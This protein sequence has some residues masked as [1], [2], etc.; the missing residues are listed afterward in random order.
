[1]QAVAGAS[2]AGGSAEF[3]LVRKYLPFAAVALISCLCASP[4]WAHGSSIAGIWQLNEG[5]SPSRL[6]I[7]QKTGAYACKEITGTINIDQIYGW[8][9]PQSRELFFTRF[10][11]GGA[12]RR[13]FMGTA[14]P[15]NGAEN[16]MAGSYIYTNTPPADNFYPYRPWS[17][18]R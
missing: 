5:G 14:V 4:S 18:S 8:Y 1:M 7:T 15:T 16:F 6:T 13:F 2:S 11:D 17:A 12:V 10:E 9:C 3:I